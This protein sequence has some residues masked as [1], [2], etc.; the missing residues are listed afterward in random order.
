MTIKKILLFAGAGLLLFVAA[1]IAGICGYSRTPHARNLVVDQIN[2]TIPGTLSAGQIQ[3]LSGGALIRLKNIQL[4]DPEETP[5]LAF[6]SLVVQIRWG[7]LL[8]KVLEVSHFQIDGL[9]LD[10]TAD[11][12][13]KIN[14]L[15]AL[16]AGDGIPDERQEKDVSRAGLPLNV[17]I[18]TA[19]ITRS[20]V[21]FSDPESTVL[22]GSLE[23]TLT[24]VDLQ[25]MSGAV[26]VEL[27]DMVFSSARETLDAE[28]LSLFASVKEKT[29][30]SF[31]MDL[32]SSVGVL[33]ASGSVND[34]FDDPQV[35]L[36]ADL[37][38]DLTAVSQ[39]FSDSSDLGGT[40]H[41]TLS[42]H[43]PVND[44]VA[45]LRA[46]GQQLAMG[47]DIQ[48]GRL[49]IAVDLA[50][51]VLT[52]DPAQVSLLGITTTV[53]GS[54]DLSQVFPDGF[55][56][57]AQDM[58]KLSYSLSFNQ[59]GG[60]FKQLTPWIPGFSG[61]F[62]SR[63]R[64]QGR[65]VSVDT[66]TAGYELTSI[67][68]GFK[69]D[70]ADIDPLDLDIQ[71]SG[72]IDNRLLTLDQLTVGTLPAQ[73]KGSGTY[74]LTD[75]VLDMDVTVSSN[76]LNTAT[77][78]FGLFPARGR[79]SAVIQARG[80]VSGPE[81][82]AVLEGRD[83]GAA[84]MSVDR[85]DLKATLDRQGK[86]TL[87]DLTVQGPG[88]DLAASGAA[89]LFDTGFALKKQI[90]ATLKAKGKVRPETVLA[91]TETGVNSRFPDTD[92]AFDL[93]ARIAY[94]M[95]TTVAIS[96]VADITIPQQKMAARIDLNDTRVSL[97]LEDLVD[98]TGDLD[99]KTSEYAVDANFK[100]GEFSALLSAAGITGISGGVEGWFRST[101]TLPEDLTAPLEKHLAA[102]KGSVTIEADVSGTVNQ[103]DF[104]AVVDLKD[105]AW[106]PA[107]LQLAIADL[108][109]RM[110]LSP[111]RLT[112]QEMT[113][114]VNQ[115]RMTLNGE[116]VVNFGD[117]NIPVFEKKM[118]A[119]TA[120]LSVE[121]S[122]ITLPVADSGTETVWV[123]SLDSSLN[124]R[125][126]FSQNQTTD[127]AGRSDSGSGRRIPARSILAVL[128]LNRPD[129]KGLDLSVTLDQSIGLKAA[130]TP[131]TSQFDVK[132]T[133]SA[134]PLGPFLE[135]A[136]I[137]GILGQIDGQL[138]TR[139]RLDMNLPPQ[140][141]E[142]LKPAAGTL[143]VE[144]DVAGSFSAPE[145]NARITLDGLRYPVPEAGLVVSDFNGT[146]TLSNDR[147]EITSLAAN[148][149]QGTLEISGDLGLENFM[150]VTGQARVVTQNVRISVEDTLET[151]FNTDL[152]FSGSREKAR[153]TGTVEMIH[154]EYYRDF[155][156]DLAEALESR[157]MGSVNPV[158]T[159]SDPGAPSF[160]ENMGLNI[161]LNYRDPF[162]LDNNLAFIMVE[163]DLKITG[164]ARQPV[165]T[166][167]A[168]IPEG[169]VVY[170]KRQFD[171]ETGIIDFVDPFKIDPKITLKASTVIRDWVI[172]MDV[173]GKTDNLRFRLYS[174]PAETHEDILSL[175]VM[176]KT[177]KELGKGGGTFTGILADRASEMVGREVAASTPLDTFKLGYDESGGQGGSVSV[178]MGKK[179]SDRLEVIYSM[180]TEDQETVHTNAAEYK[181][182]EN[183]IL[184]AFND[185]Q[186]DFGTEVTLKLE[187]R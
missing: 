48:D 105:L 124:L 63:G 152:T 58:D 114:R 1:L 49:D 86:A 158:D 43:G 164:T 125:L 121:G 21:S 32:N 159:P 84:G 3:L 95:G 182:L 122:D 68:K 80:P 36:T 76:D 72:D 59:T 40:I 140:L 13:G 126:D 161:D 138:Q 116:A 156:F 168:D 65:G 153:L 52:L 18:K 173:S 4:L 96:D 88:L 142:H 131:E 67:F 82:V 172:Y 101:G 50:Q 104:N 144:A 46:T 30:G 128:G 110:I 99:M 111:Y 77:Q 55:M 146:A 178:T 186:G 102:V 11:A 12:N 56:H 70:Q 129:Q 174:D 180:D 113:T 25:Q 184:R 2:A 120:T 7:A 147:L 83:L 175:L 74:H 37:T 141:G 20:T 155:A 85:L 163:P 97:Y 79:V 183:V 136:G 91:E 187:F 132:G 92:A 109:G 78:A 61:Q 179:L 60:D 94:D 27:G 162:I 148:L 57:P 118:K 90:Q 24:G 119:V 117:A 64:V 10:L 137:F 165:I 100:A 127:A 71:V 98:I 81:I 176:G 185:S 75:Q 8:D 42:S 108:N 171:I 14:L 35:D 151:A 170:Q 157:K 41:V 107:G 17:E 44:P 53:S 34:L 169:T 45:K 5:C 28:S 26:A 16:V 23:M 39:L 123:E 166:G 66:L 93:K 33:T 177:T 167:R 9:N 103:P 106:Q 69:Q 135:T 73:V 134:T 139:G 89:D 29:S 143:K 22:V 31:Q 130:F 150:P 87:E 149:N 154:G 145:V 19:Q 51:R 181:M 133:F 160:I 6:D 112:I 62:S 47:P 15:D 38:T 54:T 115:G